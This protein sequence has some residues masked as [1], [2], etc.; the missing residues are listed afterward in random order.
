MSCRPVSGMAATSSVLT[1]KPL[2]HHRGAEAQRREDESLDFETSDWPEPRKSPGTPF[3]TGGEQGPVHGIGERGEARREGVVAMAP[4]D[5][6]GGIFALRRDAL[7]GE[8]LA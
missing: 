8:E 5:A 3:P 6:V 4:P 7:P 1:S 2:F